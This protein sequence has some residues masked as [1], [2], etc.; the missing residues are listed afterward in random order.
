MNEPEFVLPDQAK[1]AP[2]VRWSSIFSI[3]TSFENFDFLSES[4]PSDSQAANLP[5]SREKF[6]C[7]SSRGPFNPPYHPPKF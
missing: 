6:A 7:F 2:N 3:R 4:P 5:N 1:M